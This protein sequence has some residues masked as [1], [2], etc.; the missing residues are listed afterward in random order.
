[1]SEHG[2][3][4]VGGDDGGSGHYRG[5]MDDWSHEGRA[6]HDR[7]ALVADGGRHGAHDGGAVEGGSEQSWTG[8]GQSKESGQHHQ[9]EHLESIGLCCAV[10]KL[11]LMA[12]VFSFLSFIDGWMDMEGA[13][14][15]VHFVV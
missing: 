4:G 10:G 13:R 11:R 1:M 14:L 15:I 9:F 5:S 7:A 2:W 6:V 8:C 12:W 3:G